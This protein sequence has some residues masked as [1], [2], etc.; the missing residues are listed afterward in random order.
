MMLGLSQRISRVP[1]KRGLTTSTLRGA[2][3]HS[4]GPT[5]HPVQP[6]PN[7]PGG[8]AGGVG[9]EGP[10][11]Q[12][13]GPK[14]FGPFRF[15]NQGSLPEFMHDIAISSRQEPFGPQLFLRKRFFLYRGQLNRSISSC[16]PR[17]TFI[18]FKTVS[19]ALD[20]PLTFRI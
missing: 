6:G 2:T 8:T 17:L 19:D 4:L 16:K 10:S 12:D 3:G 7:G 13:R 5:S 18:K 15:A 20:N 14:G 9:D 1:V 11:A